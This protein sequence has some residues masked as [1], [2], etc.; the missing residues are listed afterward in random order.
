M[1]SESSMRLIKNV[2][3]TGIAILLIISLS[4][5]IFSY[6]DKLSFYQDFQTEYDEELQ[7]NKELKSELKKSADSYYVEKEI[8]EQLQLLKPN[9]VAVIMPAI[10]ISPTP[11]PTPPKKPAEQWYDLLIQK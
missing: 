2:I 5:N 7:T 11:S 1:G 6:K 9:E 3:I 10:T 4:K 8:R